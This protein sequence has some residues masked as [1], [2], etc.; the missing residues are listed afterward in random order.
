MLYKY[1]TTPKIVA[2]TYNKQSQNF[3]TMK[4]ETVF[5]KDLTGTTPCYYGNDGVILELSW[6]GKFAKRTYMELS[7]IEHLR[8]G[9]F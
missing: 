1:E 9:V 2:E 8:I 6:D 3:L 5:T 7:R 4:P